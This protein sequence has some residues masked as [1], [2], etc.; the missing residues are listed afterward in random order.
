MICVFPS[1]ATDFSGNGTGMLSPSLCTVTETLN[2]EYELTLEHPLDDGGKWQRLQEGRILRVP[3]P[4]A[5]TPQVKMISQESYEVYK[6]NAS[7]RPIRA[8]A[9][10]N[11]KILAKYKKGKKVVILKKGSTWYEVTGPD[12]KHGYMNKAHLTYVETKY[13]KAEATGEVIEPQQ[14]RDQPFRIYRIVPSLDKVTVYARHIFYDL[15]DNMLKTLKPGSTLAGAGVVDAISGGCLTEH[16]FDFYSDLDSTSS[17]MELENVNPVD[18]I[19]G[20]GGLLELYGG[21][22]ARDWFDVY[23]VQRVGDDTDIQI[24]EGKNLL[25]VSYDVDTTDVVTRIMPT[26]ED[27]DGNTLWLP[28]V[29]IDS[30]YVGQY[31]H[32]KWI[33]LPVS[34]ARE[35]PKGDDK[36]T[37]AQCYTEMRQAAQDEFAKGCDVPCVTLTVDF[38]NTAETEEYRD[39]HLLQNIYLGD[40]VRVVAPRIGISV[41]MR[42]T[43]YTYDCLIKKYT[44][45]TLGTVAD[46]LE[47]SMI[48]S[49]QIP[50]GSISG[51]KLAIN[52]VGSMQLRA[53]SILAGHVSAESI[54]TEKLAAAAVTAEKLAAGSVDAGA[55]SAITAKIGSLTASDID[56]DAL[57]AGLAAFTVITCGTAGFDRATVT[58][59]VAQAL[60]LSFG[61]GD[62]VMINNLRVAYAQ[63]ISA[64]IGNLCVKASD[65]SYYTIDVDSDGN[66]T[67]TPATVT[68]EEIAAGETDA[69]RVILETDILADNL[70]TT[71]LLATYALV[72]RIDAA[73]IDVDQLFAREAFIARL[74]TSEIVAGKSLTIIAGEASEAKTLAEGAVAGTSILYASGES[75]STAPATGWSATPPE[76]QEG[77]YVWQKTVTTYVNGTT[78]KS[79]PVNISG[80]DGEPATVLRIDS[81]RGTVFKNNLVSTTLSAVIYRGPER[82]TDMT[83]LRRVFGAG[84]Y[85]QWSWQRLD[86][87]RFG[88][89]SADDSRI[90]AG[91]FSLTLS[92]E[93][94]DTKVTFMCEL[95]VD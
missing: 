42:L 28:E 11:G 94:V 84:A 19:M 6:T 12:G 62:Y 44:S 31:V 73:R 4:A 54:T 93:D 85:L 10:S 79:P 63:V 91:G 15:L 82:I 22:L 17:E 37:K 1:D 3:V 13:R 23:V 53:D 76:H 57:A 87:D 45:M 78:T 26:G 83:G 16:E 5:A 90:G 89:I 80:A 69:G 47:G 61:V 81:S 40:A 77:R 49:R 20:D 66:V 36:K 32:P 9:K 14:L 95:I 34:D 67:A 41:S 86:E 70:S 21:E 50:A 64:T 46:T 52:S 58:H 18:A 27:K 48:S 65:G 2:G 59:L 43:Q 35:V 39:Y 68:E 92:P 24:R 33:H 51:A 30:P 7:N 71:N 38:I 55:L 72:N 29:F 8:K 25:G 88:V 74:S 56:T 60:N 75:P